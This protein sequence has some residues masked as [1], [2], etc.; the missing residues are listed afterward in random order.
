MSKPIAIL[1][2]LALSSMSASA[3]FAHGGGCK[4]P[5]LGQCCH[6]QSA[7]GAYHCH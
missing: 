7:T 6:T 2:A 5:N 1:A 3:G 4:Q